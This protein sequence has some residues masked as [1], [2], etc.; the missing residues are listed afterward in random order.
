MD[1]IEDLNNKIKQLTQKKEKT[2]YE[3]ELY[4]SKATKYKTA[5]TNS[6]EAMKV[7][8]NELQTAY[9]S[10]ENIIN[11]KQK[12]LLEIRKQYKELDTEKMKVEVRYKLAKS[13]I[14]ELQDTIKKYAEQIDTKTQSI[15]RFTSQI[16]KLK[17]QQQELLNEIAWKCKVNQDTQKIQEQNT[18]RLQLKH[19]KKI[20]NMQNAETQLRLKISNQSLE[21]RKLSN[22]LK[23]FELIFGNFFDGVQLP[24]DTPKVAEIIANFVAARREVEQAYEHVKYI[25]FTLGFLFAMHVF[26]IWICI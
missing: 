21:I 12:Q 9:K 2:E 18:E 8:H 13:T 1:Q 20:L 5:T 10:Q 16:G 23:D 7:Q 6:M 19:N 4:K 26:W 11:L 25:A 22:K 17:D 3:L 15:S 14:I 24:A